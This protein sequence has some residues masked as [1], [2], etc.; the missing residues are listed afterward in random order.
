MQN[1]YSV[2]IFRKF[3]YRNKIKSLEKLRDRNNEKSTK[4][5]RA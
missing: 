5:F 2:Y 4:K 3:R 1:L